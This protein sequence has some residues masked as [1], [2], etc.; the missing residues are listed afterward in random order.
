MLNPPTLRRASAIDEL[1][2][3]PVLA[4]VVARDYDPNYRIELVRGQGAKLWDREG[5]EFI[6]LLCGYS[7]TNFGH[8][9]PS[10]VE[11]AQ[12][13][14]STL[15]HLTGAQHPGRQRLAERLLEIF[16]DSAQAARARACQRDRAEACQRPSAETQWPV[17]QRPLPKSATD[18]WPEHERV[19]FNSTGA[20]AIESAWK[21]A[22]AY[23]P[24]RLLCLAPGFHGRSITTMHLSD[25]PRGLPSTE[26]I[27]HGGCDLEIEAGRPLEDCG[28]QST[29]SFKKRR[30]FEFSVWPAAEYPNCQRCPLGLQYPSCEVAC[31]TRLLDYIKGQA[32]QISAVLVEP[33]LGARGYVFPPDEFFLKLRTTTAEHG[34][35]MIADEIQTGLGRCGHWSLA[36]MQGWQPDLLV[37]GKS[38]G[39][40]IAPISAVLGPQA[41]LDALPSGS[42]SETFAATPMAC[43]VALQVLSELR[44]GPWIANGNTWGQRLRS[45]MRELTSSRASTISPPVCV[46]GRG[47]VCTLEFA[48]EL[49]IHGSVD[50]SNPDATPA[51]S[52]ARLAAR[53][54]VERA[55]AAGVL[56]HLSGRDRTRVVMLPPFV[57]QSSDWEIV[58]AGMQAAW[59]AIDGGQRGSTAAF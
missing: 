59:T 57:L 3:E 9:F 15:Q 47:A 39:G 18:C 14:L 16:R 32:E 54:F 46:S 26:G 48:G 53:T 42:E 45:L 30:Q 38:L 21:A 24:G 55:Q 43:G 56:V 23:R 8:S 31:Q 51:Q 44:N 40:G 25:S 19:L 36:H 1:D 52:D 37:V 29:H 20:R 13:Q 27:I 50:T 10:F 58:A 4:Q 35:L 11:A 7:V 49:A 17:T 41:V 22:V 5:R 28:G 12:Q 2:L 6:D 33:A 34:I